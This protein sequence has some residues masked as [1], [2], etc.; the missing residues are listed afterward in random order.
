[1][2][3]RLSLLLVALCAGAAACKFSPVEALPLAITLTAS[4]S[5]PAAGDTVLFE[6]NAQGGNLLAV[7]FD[8]SD[9]RVDTIPTSGARTATVRRPHVFTTRASYT[10]Q[11]VIV[12]AVAG[13][14]TAQKTITVR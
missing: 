8:Y 2:M 5:N 14:A 1:M 7:I 12:D 4:T 6:V 10:V 3:R 9:T 11:A 13:E